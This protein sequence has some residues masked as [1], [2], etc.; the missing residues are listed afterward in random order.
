MSIFNIS[1]DNGQIGI[2]RILLIFYLLI[3]LKNTELPSNNQ[4][5]EFISENVIAQHLIGIMTIA[6]LISYAGDIY[7]TERIVKYTAV[8]YL[9]Y[10][11]TTKLDLHW[12]II[13]LSL[14]SVFNFLENNLIDTE[15]RIK[16]DKSVDEEKKEEILEKNNRQRNIMTG[17]MISVVTVGI[18][19]YCHKKYK[20]YGGDYDISKFIL[21]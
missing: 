21:F 10:V 13:V 7:D 17:I 20:Q 11:S 19:L 2:L 4:L 9:L 14:L 15:K 1:T 12:S 18:S 16:E 6:V 8:C 5:K 3:C